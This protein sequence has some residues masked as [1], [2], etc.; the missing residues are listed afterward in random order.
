MSF[1]SLA[2]MTAALAFAAFGSLTAHAYD[3]IIVFGDSYNDVGNIYAV[4]S[5]LGQ[6]YP[7]PPYYDGR[8]SNGP[9]WIEHIASD[10]GLPLTPSVLGGTDYAFG[11]AE[12][13]APVTL[14]GQTIP[15]V[16]QQ[17]GA[18]LIAH[19]GKADP[20]ALY[21][22]EGGGNDILDATDISSPSTLGTAIGT[23]IYGIERTLRKA[24]AKSFLIPDV[25]NV[26]QLPAAAANANSAAFVKFA[27]NA[28][29][30][31]NGAM[32]S[33]LASD[34]QLPGI[35]IHRLPVFRT[36]VAVL[37]DQTHFGFTNVVT[38][39][40]TQTTVCA[41]PDHT[42]WWDAEHPSEFGHAF[43]AVLVEERLV[44]H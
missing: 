19:G 24:G 27:L 21:V 28:S 40:L 10:W 33:L 13:L 39:C 41:D 1:R 34:M 5:A 20:H 12:L 4:S 15:S 18:Y 23:A 44:N 7:P 3:S 11:G 17:V 38:P 43:F 8:F 29:I 2:H 35:E 37:K 30:Y 32:V 6:P 26:G 9:I 14:D 31:A 25:L 22:L 36:Y 42:L 16:E